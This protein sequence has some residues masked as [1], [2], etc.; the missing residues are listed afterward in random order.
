MFSG[1]ALTFVI[2][3]FVSVN[4]QAQGLSLKGIGGRLSFV[5]PEDIDGTIGVGAHVNLGEIVKICN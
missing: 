1:V 5:K 2:W 4:S 3:S